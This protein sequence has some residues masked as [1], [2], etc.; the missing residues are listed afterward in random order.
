[1]PDPIRIHL[2]GEERRF[3]AYPLKLFWFCDIAGRRAR[4]YDGRDANG[5]LWR[6][7]YMEWAGCAP[8]PQ[9]AALALDAALQPLATVLAAPRV[10]ELEAELAKRPEWC[11]RCDGAGYTESHEGA[12]THTCGACRGCGMLRPGRR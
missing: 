11:D 6:I 5:P 1:M 12:I 2:L 7:E 9:A 8:D 10:R 4:L 3:E